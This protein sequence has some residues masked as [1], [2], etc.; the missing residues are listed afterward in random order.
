MDNGKIL[1]IVGKDA[2]NRLVPYF[3]AHVSSE[4]KLCWEWALHAFKAAY[5]DSPLLNPSS[6]KAVVFADLGQAFRSALSAVLPDLH[7][8]HCVRH[9]EV[10]DTNVVA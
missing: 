10:Y 9:R 4:D 5:K 8:A 1:D 7:F 3:V 6:G 2:C